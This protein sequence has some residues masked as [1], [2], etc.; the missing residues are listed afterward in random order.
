MKK[1]NSD[2]AYLYSSHHS[3]DYTSIT[4]RWILWYHI[5][6]EIWKKRIFIEYV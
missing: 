1:K 2:T 5:R 4:R 3:I 6:M